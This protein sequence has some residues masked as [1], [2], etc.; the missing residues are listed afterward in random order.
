MSDTYTTFLQEPEPKDRE[1]SIESF[2]K[3]LLQ[4][5]DRAV[6]GYTSVSLAGL[7]GNV[8]LTPT[9][10]KHRVIKLTGVPS[11][12]VTVR[13]PATTGANADIHLVNAC[14]GSNSTVTVKST[15]ANTGHSSGVSLVTGYG[16]MVRHDGESAYAAGAAISVSTGALQ[17]A[18]E[19]VL[20]SNFSI[21]GATTVY[22]DSGL[23]VTLPGPGT[24]LVEADVRFGLNSAVANNFI[25]AKFYNS[26]DAADVANS[27]TMVGFGGAA[28]T[29]VISTTHMHKV[30]TVTASKVI[31]LYVMRAGSGFTTTDI[32]SD[33][34]GRTRM[35]YRQLA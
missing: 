33:S 25:A 21:T 10:A 24:Y 7:T 29:P 8:D 16:R 15:G 18:G 13:I 5:L 6:A 11:G 20:G 2:I 34:N 1:Q 4:R 27:E 12:A 32:V 30:V 35:S 3:G 19:A 17:S 31:K 26:T 28:S 22:Q 9:Q 23:S 14:T